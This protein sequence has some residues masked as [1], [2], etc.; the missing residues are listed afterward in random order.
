MKGRRSAIIQ[1]TRL[2]PPDEEATWSAVYELFCD[3]TTS[4]LRDLRPTLLNL[5]YEPESPDEA[6]AEVPDD[7]EEDHG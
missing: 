5:R 1:V 7:V 3:A 2:L 6:H 4:V